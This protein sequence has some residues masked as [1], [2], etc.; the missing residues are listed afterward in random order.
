MSIMHATQG[1]KIMKRRMVI[2]GLGV[3]SPL[4]QNLPTF[5]HLLRE[6]RS[7][8][9]QSHSI[10]S[11]GLSSTLVGA[12]EDFDPKDFMEPKRARR[13]GRA[14]QFAVAASLM[15]VHDAR[16]NWE[17]EDKEAVGVCIGS[18][19]AGLSEALGAHA[20]YLKKGG[21]H[22]N[23]FTMTAVFPN[24]VSGEVAITFGVHGPCETY[25]NGCSSTANALGR[26]CELIESGQTDLMIVGG[27]EAPLSHPILSAMDAGRM[28]A[29]DEGGTVSNLPRPFD[30]TRCGTVI[31]EGAGCF[32]LEEYEHAV[33]RGA[34]IYCEIEAWSFTC[35]AFSMARPEQS[36][37]EQTRAI[38]RTLKAANWFPEEVDYINACGLGTTDLDAI[39]T[40]AIKQA[41]G[42]Q[43]YRVPVTSFKAALGHAFAASG[44]FQVVGTSL[45]LEN[46][47]IPPTLNLA[48]PDPDCD[49]DYV[50]GM[51]REAKVQRAL[52]NSF[53]FGGKN[54]V[55]AVSKPNCAVAMDWDHTS[56]ESRT[57]FA[58]PGAFVQATAEA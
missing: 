31:G 32:V 8:I 12:V 55:L 52:I 14:S 44:A 51:G 18:S 16:I 43:A 7:G 22:F 46:Q 35:D 42:S 3:V 53:G 48:V 28:L 1:G 30:K 38:A 54:V 39:E 19:I 58:M 50:P 13:M 6:G 47:F 41:L 45:V 29:S 15:A 49:L 27:T 56:K 25:S 11:T 20:D 40:L 57:N 2:S 17:W 37:K 36:A 5:W 26:A 23:P 33:R 34:R 10:S 9:R 24:A 21:V 4:G